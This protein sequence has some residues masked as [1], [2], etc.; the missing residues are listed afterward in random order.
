[1][2][3]HSATTRS[4]THRARGRRA[5]VLV[6]AVAPLLA[7]CAA[8]F[9]AQT[10]QP[11]Q[12][13][14]GITVRQGAVFVIDTLVVANDKGNGTVVAALVNQANRADS[15]VIVT[16]SEQG[17]P[18]RV[19]NTAGKPI[20]LPSQT[21]VQLA[22]SGDIR[23][24]GHFRPGDIV[25]LD[26]EFANAAPV[27][28]DAPVLSDSSEYADVPVGP[29]RPTAGPTMTPLAPTTATSTP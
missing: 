7:G 9:S 6:A 16:A 22:N 20:R 5:A 18:L 17:R 25:T 27:R 29:V 28:I 21:G 3:T 10:N 2:T 13:A 8:G 15:L 1:M 26:F 19:T 24:D 23:V 14:E 4:I 11:Y 12:P